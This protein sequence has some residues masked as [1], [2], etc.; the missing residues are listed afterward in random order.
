[1]DGRCDSYTIGINQMVSS[2]RLWKSVYCV[3]LATK[4]AASMKLRCIIV[5]T[6]EKT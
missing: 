6:S 1:M 4:K 5:I 3:P 2:L